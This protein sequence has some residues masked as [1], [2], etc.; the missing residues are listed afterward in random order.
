MV[1]A[2]PYPGLDKERF[3]NDAD[4]EILDLTDVSWAFGTQWW[5]V[6]YFLHVLHAKTRV[7]LY[8]GVGAALRTAHIVE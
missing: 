1:T 7:M 4:A 3:F 6:V 5:N 8:H 2:A